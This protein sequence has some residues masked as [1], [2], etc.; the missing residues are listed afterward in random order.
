MDLT[1]TRESCDE[2]W[3]FFFRNLF[4]QNDSGYMTITTEDGRRHMV[5]I[6]RT[7]Y[8]RVKGYI[9]DN[10]YYA[11]DVCYV[12]RVICNPRNCEEL[13]YTVQELVSEVQKT[14]VAYAEE[15]YYPF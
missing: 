13:F 6:D 12:D 2:L 7:E 8:P 14:L 15:M 1:I 3:G 5:S 4:N 11:E 10:D 9:S